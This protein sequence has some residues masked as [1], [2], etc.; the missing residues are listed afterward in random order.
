M[1]KIGKILIF[2]LLIITGQSYATVN[3]VVDRT[4]LTEGESLTLEL[5]ISGSTKASTPNL[6]ALKKDFEVLGTSQ[7]TQIQIMNGT[8]QSSVTWQVGLE[9]KKTGQLIIPP[10]KI[11]GEETRAIT[12]Q[13]RVDNQQATQGNSALKDF[14]V[15]VSV[16]P[17][18]AYVQ[19]QLSL[20]VTLYHSKALTEGSLDEPEGENL[21]VEKLGED[22][23]Y[24]KTI[25]GKL[26][27]VVE[28]KYAITP[29]HSGEFSIAP[30]RFSGRVSNNGYSSFFDRGKRVTA[31]SKSIAISVKSRPDEF[32]KQ[33]DWIPAR[34]FSMREAWPDGLTK[35]TAGV[36]T[37][38]EL[39]IKALGLSSSQL[40]DIQ[41][42]KGQG[43]RIYP[44]QPETTDTQKGLWIEGSKTFKFAIIPGKAGELT[45]PAVRVPWWNTK[46]DS[47]EWAELPERKI[48][49]RQ[50]QVQPQPQQSVANTLETENK[51]V[52]VSKEKKMPAVPS[53]SPSIEKQWF[54]A[55]IL[56][57]LAFGF[58][59]LWVITLILWLS[60]KRKKKVSNHKTQP[61]KTNTTISLDD[62]CQNKSNLEMAE[63]VI[64]WGREKFAQRPPTGLADLARQFGDQ[65]A[66]E[67]ILELEQ[68]T[69]TREANNF[70]HCN[71]LRKA[72]Q[73]T[74]IV[75]PQKEENTH[76]GQLPELYPK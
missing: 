6:E 31:H 45:L 26:Y 30:I 8:Q 15:K 4:V 40:P 12:I 19:Q 41:V 28:R 42:L 23:R 47:L 51:N 71:E 54:S 64:Q 1:N 18:H 34:E 20:V 21:L 67:L 36:P 39:S 70:T 14:M 9:P 57:G 61:N 43:Y 76:A 72:L 35:V 29:Q 16:E 63:I 5:S 56:M 53:L 59:V 33:A 68:T 25:G 46:T 48:P 17:D 11:A 60:E 2:L 65:K 62:L 7:S 10:I 22:S 32:P 52:D 38:W 49:V 55:N 69:F 37:T 73:K 58:F 27:G 74:K 75:L 24:Q 44:D 13:V 50:G 66:S 3:A